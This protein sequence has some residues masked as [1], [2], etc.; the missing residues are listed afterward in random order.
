MK[1]NRK[2]FVVEEND[3]WPM[4]EVHGKRREWVVE[5][6]EGECRDRTMYFTRNDGCKMDFISI[7]MNASMSSRIV[8][9]DPL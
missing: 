5:F 4:N 2:A 9:I 8:D 1:I 7:E 3:I 6:C